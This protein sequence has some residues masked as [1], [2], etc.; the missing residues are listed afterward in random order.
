VFQGGVPESVNWRKYELECIR[1]AA[2]CVQLVGNVDS[3]ALQSHF[4]RMARLWS[5]RAVLRDRAR[6]R[7]RIEPTDAA[8]T[9]SR[10]C[11]T[12]APGTPDQAIAG[13]DVRTRDNL[14]VEGVG[15]ANV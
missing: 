1:L 11:Y 15:P 6:I 7:L 13:R 3:P 4:L 10:F 8:Q 14:P 5:D 2:D 12:N 9:A